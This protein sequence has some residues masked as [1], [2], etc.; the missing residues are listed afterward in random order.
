MTFRVVWPAD[1]VTRL[2]LQALV[3]ASQ[4]VPAGAGMAGPAPVVI[5]GD[6]PAPPDAA[7]VVRI[8]AGQE[9]EGPGET[10]WHPDRE[11]SRDA[12]VASSD[13]ARQAGRLLTLEE[14]VRS[15]QRDAR[16][17][18]LA[19][20]SPRMSPGL[21]S[22][23]EVDR[24]GASLA[25]AIRRSL[26]SVAQPVVRWHPWPDGAPLAVCLTHDVDQIRKYT[27]YRLKE[28]VSHPRPRFP[29]RVV[30]AVLRGIGPASTTRD[31]FWT[32]DR[33]RD[34]EA[35]VGAKSAFYVGT[36]PDRQGLEYALDRSPPLQK[37]I[38]ELA[39][40]GFEVGL[41]AHCGTPLDAG[42]MAADKGRLDAYLP[43][44]VA[45]VRQHDLRFRPPETWHRQAEAGFEYD[46]SVGFADF[47]GFRAGTC[48]PYRPLPDRDGFWE[49][50]MHLMDATLRR[51]EGLDPEAARRR[52]LSVM[53][54]VGAVGGVLVVNWHNNTFETDE[55]DP[56][57]DLYA[58]VL[59]AAV[60]RSASFLVPRDVLDRW[61]AG[62]SLSV[63][64]RERRGAGWALRV[65]APNG[66][67]GIVAEVQAA[68]ATERLTLNAAPGD[69]HEIHVQA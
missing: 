54:E 11:G 34:L 33:I 58:D 19:R 52:A 8:P 5:H 26:A 62:S 24:L 13:I 43:A 15:E 1:P 28:E 51:Y 47:C 6:S 36:V 35:R 57:A 65:R 60:Q 44:P 67:R 10:S 56:F 66:A 55:A 18:F 20:M 64:G 40:D 29:A 49:L 68:G 42:A 46:T 16:G 12:F 3:A 2:G 32:F 63:A 31:P 48:F 37:L 23:A 27:L 41:H 25:A 45:G 50:P 61:R 22:R 38:A 39:R 69:E 9:P 53:D 14:E 7:C 4:L 21:L 59:S 17:R 30:R